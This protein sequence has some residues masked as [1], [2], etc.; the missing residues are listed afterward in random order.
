MSALEEYAREVSLGQRRGK[1]VLTIHAPDLHGEAI[2]SSRETVEALA[3]AY[4]LMRADERR[5]AGRIR[6]MWRND[7]AEHQVRIVTDPASQHLA[8]TCVCR[9][10]AGL[11]PLEVRPRWDAE[12][13]QAVYR[14]HLPAE[15]GET[16]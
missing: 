9:Q 15:A 10:R 16:A 12:D 7:D 3:G 1:W 4:G 6:V 13:A 8:V 2:S 5:A 14:A 11:P